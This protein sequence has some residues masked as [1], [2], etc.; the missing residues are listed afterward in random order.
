MPVWLWD[1]QPILWF[2][3]KPLFELERGCLE[4]LNLL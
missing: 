4:V 3:L 1:T 2:D